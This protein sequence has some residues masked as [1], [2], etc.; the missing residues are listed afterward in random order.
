MGVHAVG[1]FGLAV[2]RAPEPDECDVFETA[3]RNRR[4]PATVSS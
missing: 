4:E 1:W 3:L 2:P